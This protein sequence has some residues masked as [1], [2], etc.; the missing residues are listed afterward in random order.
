MLPLLV[1]AS[2]S[3]TVVVVIRIVKLMVIGVYRNVRF[4]CDPKVRKRFEDEVLLGVLVAWRSSRYVH[5]SRREQTADYLG[6]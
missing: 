2:F 6:L 3:F 5:N 4:A 1:F